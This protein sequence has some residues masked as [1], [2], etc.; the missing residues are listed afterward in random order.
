ME[1]LDLAKVFVVLNDEK[2]ATKIENSCDLFERIDAEFGNFR[3]HELISC[4]EFASDWCTWEMHPY[5]D[6]VVILLSGE[7]TLFLDINGQK[8]EINLSKTGEYV[9]IQKGVWHTAHVKNS[10][11]MLFITPGQGTENRPV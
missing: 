8:S 7:A 3:G 11:K 5:G 1:A 2:K 6:E 4:F 9:I 10:A